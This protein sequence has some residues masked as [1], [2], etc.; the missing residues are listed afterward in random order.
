MEKLCGNCKAFMTF[1]GEETGSCNL[2]PPVITDT[3]CL[4]P[5]VNPL[6]WCLDWVPKAKEKAE[7]VPGAT[8]GRKTVYPSDFTPNERAG[9][10]AK[11]QGQNLNALLAEFKDFHTA[12]GSLF[13]DWQAA[14]RTWLRNAVKFQEKRR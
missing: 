11:A 14:F 13:A 8:N 1:D 6:A 5:I 7:A 3:G 12:K 10:I 9:Q 2:H 4:W